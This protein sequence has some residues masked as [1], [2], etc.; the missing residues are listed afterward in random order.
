MSL[1]D[2]LEK[3]K[4]LRVSGDITDEEYALAKAKLLAEDTG[5]PAIAPLAEEIN[6]VAEEKETRQWAMLLHLS[7]LAGYALPFAGIVAP[8]V[9]WQIK[10]NQLPGLDT[11]GKNAVNWIISE[12]IYIVVSILLIFIIIGMPLLIAV[13]VMGIVFPVIAAVKGSNGEIWRYPLSITFLK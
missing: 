6:P 11:H 3:L 1:S 4:K 7:C 5:P 2:E 10:K 9:I 13:C 12:L 8:I